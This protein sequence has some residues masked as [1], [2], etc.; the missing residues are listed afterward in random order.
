[1]CVRILAAGG[2]PRFA[3]RSSRMREQGM[4]DARCTRGLPCKTGIRR[5]REVV[6]RSSTDRSGT[7]TNYDFRGRVITCETTNGNT[8]T[9]YDPPVVTSASSPR[10]TR[11]QCGI[12]RGVGPKLRAMRAYQTS[13]DLP[14]AVVQAFV[15]TR[16]SIS[17]GTSAHAIGGSILTSRGCHCFGR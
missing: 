3:F 10:T 16:P 7:V 11:T 4:P 17:V 12:K 5:F 2:A 1:M 14:V 9:V 13:S 15:L 8:T 6:G